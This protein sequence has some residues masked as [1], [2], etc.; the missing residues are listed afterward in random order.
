[1]VAESLPIVAVVMEEV[2]NFTE[3]FKRDCVSE[4][5]GDGWLDDVGGVDWMIRGGCFV[6]GFY[7]VFSGWGVCVFYLLECGGWFLC[8]LGF[9][10]VFSCVQD[11]KSRGSSEVSRVIF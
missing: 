4:W 10:F 5:H 1:M 6:G 9:I 3:D 11:R 8:F 7:V 2:G